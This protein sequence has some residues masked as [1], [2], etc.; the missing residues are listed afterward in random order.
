MLVILAVTLLPLAVLATVYGAVR[1][2]QDQRISENRLIESAALAAS[3]ERAVIENVKGILT[4]LAMNPDVASGDPARCGPALAEALE[5]FPGYS[6]FAVVGRDGVISC[7][8][9]PQG[10][11]KDFRNWGFW[12]QLEQ[13]SSFA[14][15]E[16]VWGSVSDRRVMAAFVPLG[17]SDGT[18]SGAVS[19]SINL[20]K[21]HNQIKSRY[22]DASSAV[23]ITDG[24]GKILLSSRPASWDRIALGDGSASA[25]DMVDADGQR[26]SYAVATLFED[27][28]PE[29]S[30]H[31]VTAKPWTR[32]FSADWWFFASYFALPLLALLLASAAI[33]VGTDHV[34][35]RWTNLL[36]DKARDIGEGRYRSPSYDFGSA[37]LEV[38][39]L[40]AEL[41][42]MARMI[43]ER[44]RTLTEALTRQTALTMELHHRVGNNLQIMESY[45]RL[46]SRMAADDAQKRPL[47]NVRR[48]IGAL[49]LVH[50]LLYTSGEMAMI[51]AQDLCGKLGEQIEA[52]RPCGAVVD[53]RCNCEDAGITIDAAV[54]VALWTVEATE[55]L[56]SSGPLNDVEVVEL[57]FRIEDERA[58]LCLERIAPL[59]PE[60]E[61]PAP[62]SPPRLL[63]AIAAQLGGQVIATNRGN[64]CTRLCLIF[65]ARSL[66]RFDRVR[67]K[68]D[69]SVLPAV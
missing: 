21:L 10:L 30:L 37:P 41:K 51:S 15:L 56:L 65:P 1:L 58:Q 36:R 43:H 9:N 27:E 8:A 25:M 69:T 67:F 20:E 38:R 29:T 13:G 23:F 33:W 64:F 35:L 61:A 54:P 44:D 45:I 57:Q 34:I 46:Q 19:A 2:H 68:T 32:F 52:S 26:W 55:A 66:Q 49:S 39:S 63:Q 31:I 47:D 28:R 5:S 11:G 12:P 60:T 6:H 24:T 59:P 18:F 50:R 3:S 17:S 14:L 42:R 7:A 48:R 16:P 40:A 4:V 62:L 53:M 22:A